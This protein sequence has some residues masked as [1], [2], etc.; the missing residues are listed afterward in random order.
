MFLRADLDPIIAGNHFS[1]LRHVQ[2]W[3]CASFFD[4]A[5]YNSLIEVN[6]FL[7]HISFM[8]FIKCCTWSHLL[9]HTE[10]EPSFV[11][12]MTYLS[13]HHHIAYKLPY[14]I[15]SQSKTIGKLLTAEILM[16]IFYKSLRLHPMPNKIH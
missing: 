16:H 2:S 1:N 7:N 10:V 11:E 15:M 6:T 4:S 3:V 14:P 13:G 9:L 5:P 12:N 8:K